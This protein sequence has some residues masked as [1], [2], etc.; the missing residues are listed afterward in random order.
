MFKTELKKSL[1]H[2][3]SFLSDEAVFKRTDWKVG[4]I[5][6]HFTLFLSFFQYFLEFM[7]IW[8]R[9]QIA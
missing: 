8:Q 1:Y 3:E 7:H 9:M 2:D 6:S 5:Q 4:T